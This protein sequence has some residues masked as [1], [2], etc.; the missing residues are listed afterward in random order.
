MHDATIAILLLGFL[1]AAI[2]DWR[3]REVTDRLW[4]VLAVI[5]AAVGALALGPS[6]MNALA[7]WLVVSLFVLEHL[8]AWDE[9]IEARFPRLPGILEIVAY[10]GVGGLL[11]WEGFARG[12]GPSGLPPEVAAVFVSVLIGRGLFELGLLY[13]GADAKAFITAGILLPLETTTILAV[14]SGASAILSIYPFP[15]T[16]LMNAALL[17]VAV[18]IA[19]AVRNLR[20]GEFEFPRGFTGYT[21]AVAELPE[22]FVWVKDPKIGR[23]EGEIAT[24]EEDRQLRIRQRDELASRGV[25]RVWVTPQIPFLLVMAAGALTAVLVGNLV[26]DLLA[27]L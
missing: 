2:A 4:Q 11:A 25:S 12:L 21:V 27:G 23:P 17:A 22:R 19:I 6:G 7:L 14:P 18:P 20:R 13:G 1:A 16:L 3:E 26:I 15:V 24:S 9:A 8:F 5:G 10:V